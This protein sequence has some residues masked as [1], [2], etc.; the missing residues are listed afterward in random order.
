[1]AIFFREDNRLREASRR[2]NESE[3]EEEE[4]EEEEGEEQRAILE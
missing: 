4:E 2:L 1:M 3:E